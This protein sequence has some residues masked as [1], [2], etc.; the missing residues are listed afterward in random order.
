MT[1]RKKRRTIRRK[2]PKRHLRKSL[3]IAVLALVLV[4][5]GI[6][7]IPGMVTDSKLRKLGYTEVQIK[8]IHTDKIADMI[9]KNQYYSE[10]LAQCIQDSTLRK[11]YISLYTK[12]DSSRGLSD[13]SL[14]L[15]NRLADIGYED[16]QLDDLFENLYDWEITPL[17]VYDYQ[18]DETEYIKDC[19]AHRGMSTVSLPSLWTATICGNSRIF[20]HP[21]P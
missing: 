18:W 20:P 4:I 8:K 5:V 21:R 12:V 1:V 13:T 14:L 11:E 19:K 10:Y 6:V 15:Y 7:K 16:D 17:L 3:V 2:G 9:L